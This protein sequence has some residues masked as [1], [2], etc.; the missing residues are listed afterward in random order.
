MAFKDWDTSLRL[1]YGDYMQLL[2]WNSA[3]RDTIPFVW[4][5][6]KEKWG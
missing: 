2:L 3:G 4:N 6:N 5:L 1:S